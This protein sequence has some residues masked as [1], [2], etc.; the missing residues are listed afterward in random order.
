MR[1]ISHL[2]GAASDMPETD[3]EQQRL[4][5]LTR[6]AAP[7]FW[8]FNPHKPSEADLRDW[9]DYTG[10]TFA[11]FLREGY[12]PYI[13]PEDHARTTELMA[14]AAAE[15]TSFS[16]GLRVKRLDGVYRWLHVQARPR[17][18]AD[19][20][21]EEWVGVHTDMTEKYA[22]QAELQESYER[23]ELATLATTEGV[24]DMKYGTGE[25]YYSVRLRELLGLPGSACT[26]Q[27]WLTRIYPGDA[28]RLQKHWTTFK[29]SPSV[30]YESEFRCLDA[31]DQWR[32]L[33]ARAVC[34]R[35]SEGRILRLTGTACDISTERLKDPLTG[36]HNRSSLLEQLLWRIEKAR[37]FARNFALYFLDLDSFKQ[38]NDS[39][40]H[41]SGD[42]VL[43]EVSRRLQS[44]MAK[45]S[46]N[47]VARLGGDE[48]VVLVTDL[49]SEADAW[50]FG[51]LLK[52]LLSAPLELAQPIR[53]SASIGIAF[54]TPGRYGSAEEMLEE[55]DMAM[56][57]AK[58]RRKGSV[59]LFTPKMRDVV[60]ARLSMEQDLRRALDE[61]QFEACYQP[62]VNMVSGDILGVEAL[63]RWKHPE[64]GW[65]SPADFIPLAEDTR[66]ILLIGDWVLD[67]VLC[68]IR[69]WQSASLLPKGFTVAVNISAHQ[70]RSRQF[71]QNLVHRCSELGVEP[72]S[73]CLEVTE[74]ALIE[75][76]D[77]PAITAELQSA[78]AA[79]FEVNLDDFGTGFSSLRYLQHFP[80]GSVK[81]DQS[82]VADMCRDPRS[83]SLVQT[84]IGLANSL[85]MGVIAEGVEREEQAAELLSM[86]CFKA[87]GFLYSTA[88]SASEVESRWL[89]QPMLAAAAFGS[90]GAVA[91]AA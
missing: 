49:D 24:W 63:L 36:L 19:G 79:G 35:N 72:R 30:R 77:L 18:H 46:G 2:H 27:D 60:T 14:R 1:Q 74:G 71:S 39:M 7:L 61:Q 42:A 53:I 17:F 40:G 6:A 43:V 48:F 80:F 29:D 34:L 5:R 67:E 87:Q 62:Q 47:V 33:R 16:F 55:A 9:L 59:D 86:G 68:Q 11:A 54:G 12:D 82:F 26:V 13:H 31:E 91:R 32:W 25:M 65:V 78:V 8:T 66:L 15:G 58:S 73:L 88:V 3:E 41:A 70:L 76:G 89:R 10:Q 52:E 28:A 64:R 84:I 50:S 56:Y 90:G 22:L 69:R 85:N 57:T 20:T 81:I 4:L 23:F 21:I 51:A 37:E 38:I 44:T 75:I 45:T 83:R